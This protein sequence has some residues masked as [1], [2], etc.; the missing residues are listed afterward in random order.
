MYQGR[1]VHCAILLQEGML[2]ALASLTV[3][4]QD[5]YAA[6]HLCLFG[7]LIVNL[8]GPLSWKFHQ[9][10]VHAVVPEK[11]FAFKVCIVCCTLFFSKWQ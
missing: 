4:R 10:G 2:P 5:V 7:Q 6:L 3:L 11:A 8:A 1:D 9:P